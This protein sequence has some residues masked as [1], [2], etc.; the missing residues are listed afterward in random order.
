MRLANA[1]EDGNAEDIRLYERQLA[2]H[3]EHQLIALGDWMRAEGGRL[4]PRQVRRRGDL[5]PLGAELQR[6]GG[7]LVFTAWQGQPESGSTTVHFPADD[8]PGTLACLDA[9]DRWERGG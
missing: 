1:R 5:G 8:L 9:L 3:Q 2:D 6:R 7:A 4:P